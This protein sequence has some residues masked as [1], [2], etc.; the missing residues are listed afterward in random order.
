MRNNGTPFEYEMLI[1]FYIFA[2][3]L[4][5]TVT[6]IL[7]VTSMLL[8]YTKEG[9]HAAPLGSNVL[10][11]CKATGQGS[12][13]RKLHVDLCIWA[14]AHD[15]GVRPHCPLVITYHDRETCVTV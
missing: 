15:P 5:D 4:K 3:E 11:A 7:V 9:W 12:K 2:Q 1:D 6:M 13:L 8:M 14:S 10:K